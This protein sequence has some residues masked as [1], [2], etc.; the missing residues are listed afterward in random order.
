MAHDE[1]R[2][3]LLGRLR[4]L[5]R[6]DTPGSF[7]PEA[8]LREG[9][10]DSLAILVLR[11]FRVL[12][13]LLI[14]TGFVVAA[15]AGALTPEGV[16]DLQSPLTILHALLTP[17]AVLALG[18]VLRFV[19]SWIALLLALA[20]ADNH[21]LAVAD[22]IS[23]W[24]GWNDRFQIAR[25]YRALRWTWA[26]RDEATERVGTVGRILAVT[27]RVVFW[28]TVVTVLLIIIGAGYAMT[29]LS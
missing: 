29:Q 13:G 27:E 11:L 22:Q 28:F 10:P 8:V 21:Y 12:S 6:A 1:E 4:A 7:A 25:A 16:R 5:R 18:I 17:L 3:Q 2:T 26:V 23:R 15:A 20:L 24:H 9:W 14:V 19:V